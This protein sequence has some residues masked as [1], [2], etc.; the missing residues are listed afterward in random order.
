MQTSRR[1]AVGLLAASAIGV[2]G[3]SRAAANGDLVLGQSAPLSGAF[4]SLGEDYRNGSLLAFDQVNGAGGVNGRKIK[5]I[6]LDD[7]YNADK[8]AENTR[9]LVQQG[10]ML[11]CFNHMFTNTVRASLP[12]AMDAG[13][14][15]VGPYTGTPEIYRNDKP[16]LFVTRASFADE[17]NKILSYVTTIGYQ[18]IAL[19][20]YTGKAGD[21]LRNDVIAGLKSRGK[22]LKVYA[23]MPFGGK[24]DTAL[25]A[26]NVLSKESPDAVILGVSASDAVAF[27]RAQKEAKQRPAYFARSFVGSNQLHEDLGADSSGIVVSQLVPSPFNPSGRVVREYLDLLAKRDAK[28][29]PSFVEFEGFINSKLMILALG[30]AGANVTRE[31]LAQSISALGRVD[32]GG[33]IVDFSG[34]KHIGSRYVELTMLRADG[35]FA[36]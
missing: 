36:K 25:A 20:Y 7:A 30:K 32:L 33:Y 22:S 9:Q 5:L 4:K 27:L 28:A 12:I 24:P 1:R 3:A 18:R 16:L 13:V 23:D 31:S 14:P 8:A 35:T 21:E 26:S 6:S 2:H 17:L 34:G 11:C 15:Y 19:V 29:I 10:D